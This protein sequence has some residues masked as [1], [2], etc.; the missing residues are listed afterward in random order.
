MFLLNLENLLFV[1]GPQQTLKTGLL[2]FLGPFKQQA[3][4]SLDFQAFRAEQDL[5]GFP[6]KLASTMTADRRRGWAVKWLGFKQLHF[7]QMDAVPFL[8][9][10]KEDVFACSAFIR[11][12][13]VK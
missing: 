12:L 11:F 5:S 13:A 4:A 10:S 2:V 6:I 1:S 8:S 9:V 7:G 3:T